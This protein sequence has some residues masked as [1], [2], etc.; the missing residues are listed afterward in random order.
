[1]AKNS[2]LVVEDE[3]SLKELE[4][5]LLASKGYAV[6]AVGDGNEALEAILRNRPDLVVLDVMIPGPDGFEVCRAIKDDL[7]TCSIPVVMLTGKKSS[8]DL[9]RGRVAGADAYLTKPFKSGKLLE[10]VEGLLALRDA[11]RGEGCK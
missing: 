6:T 5:I 3:E 7:Q 8:H 10:V 4:T 1:M 2:I 9:E 11:A